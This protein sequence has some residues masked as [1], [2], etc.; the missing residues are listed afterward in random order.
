MVTNKNIGNADPK[1]Y[2]AVVIIGGH[3]G[4]IM[5]TE[6]KVLDFINSAYNNGAVIGGIGGGIIPIIAAGIIKGKD[7]TGN[8][9]VSFRATFECL[10]RS[11]RTG[12]NKIFYSR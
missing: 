9:Q 6:Q 7:C 8:E 2:D 11:T 1:D 3:S 12:W 5:S 4:D 10:C